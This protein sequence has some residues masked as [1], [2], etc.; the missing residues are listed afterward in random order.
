[1]LVAAFAM[2]AATV[3][4]ILQAVLCS[5]CCA[6]HA[7][8]ACFAVYACSACFAVYGALCMLCIAALRT[9]L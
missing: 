1:M 8:S 7:C 5:A 9:V 4:C 6:L 3:V 2:P